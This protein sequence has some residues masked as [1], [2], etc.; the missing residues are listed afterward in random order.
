MIELRV[1]SRSEFP[2][3]LPPMS[4]YVGRGTPAGNEFRIGQD[5][6]RDTVIDKY[7]ALKSKDEA[8]VAWVKANFKGFHL[9]CHCAPKRCHAGW[10]M[11]IANDLPYEP[12][13]NVYLAVE[14]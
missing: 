8:F 3:H 6:D 5:G 12:R 13:R 4:K 7:I 11:A 10:L 2:G 9:V 1:L 14:C